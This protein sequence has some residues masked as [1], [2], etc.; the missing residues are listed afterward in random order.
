MT[1]VLTMVFWCKL[2]PWYIFINCPPPCLAAGA[3]NTFMHHF[4]NVWCDFYFEFQPAFKSQ[5]IKIIFTPL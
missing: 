4:R 1:T 5:D 3:G 2:V